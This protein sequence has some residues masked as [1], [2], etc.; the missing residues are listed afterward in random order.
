MLQR[1]RVS[2]WRVFVR[3]HLWVPLIPLMVA[4]VT[5]FIGLGLWN[6][7][8]QM[9]REGVEAVAQVTDR[10]IRTTTDSDGNR[11]TRYIVSYAFR[12]SSDQRVEA[13]D[14]VSRDFYDGLEVGGPVSVRF[15][16]SDPARSQLQPAGVAG[17]VALLIVAVVAAGIMVVLAWFFWGN[18]LSILRAARSGEVREARVT[19]SEATNVQVNGRTQYRVTWT[20]AAGQPGRSAMMDYQALPR[21]GEVLRIYVDPRTGRGWWEND[22]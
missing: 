14:A 19:G 6:S 16:P 1:K 7:A 20:D 17:P 18:K 12:P 10:R 5:G 21:A 3:H 9:A 22:F 2:F 13:E 8:H 4:L 11:T 15:L